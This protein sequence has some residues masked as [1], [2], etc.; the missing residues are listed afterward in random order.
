VVGILTR[1]TKYLFRANVVL[2]GSRRRDRV[3]R[4][5]AEFPKPNTRV[6]LDAIV[7]VTRVT[8]GSR[9]AAG[10]PPGWCFPPAPERLVTNHIARTKPP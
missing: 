10:A 1:L 5:R 8:T 3:V 4:A 9:F 7:S 2:T 6:A